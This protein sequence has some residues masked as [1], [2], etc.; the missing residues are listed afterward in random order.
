MD[1]QHLSF[2]VGAPRVA[3]NR[4]TDDYQS[5]PSKQK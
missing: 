3:F 1:I 4:Q 2:R 5:L